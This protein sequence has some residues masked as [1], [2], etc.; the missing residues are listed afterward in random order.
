[1]QDVNKSNV[2]HGKYEL[3]RLLGIG[4]FAKVYQS[5]N[6]VTG[7]LVAM[8]VVSKEKLIQAGMTEQL[9]R[10]ICVMKLVNHPNIVKIY[11]VMASKTKIDLE[12][13]DGL[14]SITS[15]LYSTVD[16][17]AWIPKTMKRTPADSA[18]CIRCVYN[19]NSA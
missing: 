3:G 14:N 1:M 12:Y 4:N 9:K 5:K 8:K 16:K 17:K 19:F 11:E 2:L 18:T 15:Q 10:E 13:I 6:I 7:E